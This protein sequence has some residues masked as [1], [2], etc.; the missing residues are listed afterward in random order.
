MSLGSLLFGSPSKEQQTS[1]QLQLGGQASVQG[2]SSLSDSIARALSSGQSTSQ[3]NIA[4]ENL[5]QQ[6]YG[7]A[8]SAAAAIDTSGL[9]D[10]AKQL[11]SGG[12]NFLQQLQGNAGTD[13]LTARIGDTSTRDTQL[14]ALQQGLGQLFN[15]QL[16]PGITSQGVATGTLGGSRQAIE[17]AQAAKAVAGQYAQG[18]AQLIGMDQAQRDQ[19]AAQLAGLT[20][21]NAATGLSALPSLFGLAQGSATV[22]LTPYTA[23][24][25]ILGGPTVLT[26]QQATD[27]STSSSIAKSIADSFGQ[28]YGFDFGTSKSQGTSTGGTQGLVQAW[29]SGGGGKPW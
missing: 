19:A 20:G 27:Q 1:S 21:Q 29:L 9:S 16:L 14:S 6:L 12:L 26:Q 18:A 15:E 11:F 8:S 4:F 5:F 28:S 3:Q 25:Q 23:L 22:G 24:A 7:G 17:K 2:S 13:A 10:T